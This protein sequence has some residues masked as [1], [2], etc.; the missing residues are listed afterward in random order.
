[1][2]TPFFP[3]FRCRLAAL[4]RRTAHLLRQATLAQ[5]QQQVGDYLPAG[6]LA[7]EEEGPNSRNRVFSLRL[8]F[9]C[10]VWQMLK[11]RTSCREVTR[12]VQALLRLHGRGPIGDFADRL[13]WIGISCDRCQQEHF[14]QSSTA[15][16]DDVRGVTFLG[17]NTTC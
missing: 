9:E 5:L 14:R 4:G 12:Q 13:S 1:M 15:G 3:A 11:P 6:L 10:F 8:T 16:Q 17:C 2:P 7:S